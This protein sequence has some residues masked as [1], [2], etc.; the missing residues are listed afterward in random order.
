MFGSGAINADPY[1][2]MAPYPQKG[3]GSLL[4]NN[5]DIIRNYEVTKLAVVEHQRRKH[6]F[7]D[8]LQD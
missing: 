5:C 2:V 1:P 4:K 3:Y 7:N 8:Y 6:K